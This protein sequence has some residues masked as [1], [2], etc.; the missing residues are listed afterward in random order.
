VSSSDG[1]GIRAGLRAPLAAL[2]LAVGCASTPIRQYDLVDQPIGCDDANRLAYRTVE[3]MGYTVT[4]FQP[5]APGQRG[6]IRARRPPPGTPGEEQRMTVAIDCAPTGVS[7][8]ASRDGVLIEQVEVKRGFHHALLNVQAMA[9]AQQEL[10]AEMR[11]GTAPASQQ[12]RD[13]K[14]VIRPLRGPAS[15]LDFPFDLSAAGILPVRVDVTNLTT[16]TYRLAPD[17]V[18]LQRADRS[19]VAPLAIAAAAQQVAAARVDGAPLTALGALA[20]GELLAAHALR[21]GEIA[22]G[23]TQQGFLYFPLAEYGAAR[24]VLTD[25]ASGEEEGV[26][27][28]F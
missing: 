12:R 16:H 19:R 26:R 28:E 18:R 5:A 11:A 14:V 10:E 22:P 4:A 7:L 23:A 24:A 13:L 21:P 6:T 15:R 1:G 27:V 9:A 3:A 20:V 25:T 8:T 17:A 2:L